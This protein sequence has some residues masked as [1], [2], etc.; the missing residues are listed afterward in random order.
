MKL[1]I[2]LAKSPRKAV[3]GAMLAICISVFAEMKYVFPFS[4]FL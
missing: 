1:A 4:V 2:V 3:T